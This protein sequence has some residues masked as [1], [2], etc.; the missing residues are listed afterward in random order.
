[1]CKVTN[2]EIGVMRHAGKASNNYVHVCLFRYR[3]VCI[4]MHTHV[5]MGFKVMRKTNN[6]CSILAMLCGLICT[7]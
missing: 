7:I 2:R 5:F 1:M 6:P 4:C 3:N